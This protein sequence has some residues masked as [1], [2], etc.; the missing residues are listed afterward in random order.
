MWTGASKA[1]K[2]ISYT[3]VRCVTMLPRVFRF[4]PCGHNCIVYRLHFPIKCLHSASGNFTAQELSDCLANYIKEAAQ[5]CEQVRGLYRFLGLTADKHPPIKVNNLMWSDRISLSCILKASC[6]GQRRKSSLCG[7]VRRM[8]PLV[9]L[10]PVRCV[11]TLLDEAE[12]CFV[13]G[14]AQVPFLASVLI[15]KPQLS[16]V[17]TEEAGGNRSDIDFTEIYSRPIWIKIMFC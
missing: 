10:F 7:C 5:S 17:F 12:P 11:Y 1:V 6:N 16:S 2:T 4:I 8:P 13:S 3:R 14:S 9:Y 15:L